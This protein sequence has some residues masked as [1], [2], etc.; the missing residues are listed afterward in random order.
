MMKETGSPPQGR[1]INIVVGPENTEDNKH[2]QNL[3]RLVCYSV[4]VIS[5]YISNV[6]PEVLTPN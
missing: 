6:R 5:A 4:V 1:H 3:R 2:F